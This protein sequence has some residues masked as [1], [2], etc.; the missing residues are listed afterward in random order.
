MVVILRPH[1]Y[2]FS[3][4][5]LPPPF[6]LSSNLDVHSIVNNTFIRFLDDIKR[7][8][9]LNHKLLWVGCDASLMVAIKS[10]PL[11]RKR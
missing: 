4:F 5:P 1:S 7:H 6:L 10:A 8:Q 3:Q 2:P 9:Q 11:I